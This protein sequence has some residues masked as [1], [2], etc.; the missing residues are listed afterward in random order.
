[1][2]LRFPSRYVLAPWSESFAASL[3]PLII[4]SLVASARRG[5]RLWLT[6]YPATLRSS[7]PTPLRRGAGRPA[8]TAL[9]GLINLRGCDPK[10]PLMKWSR[11]RMIF[12]NSMSALFHEQYRSREEQQ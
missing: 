11:P 12:V 7:C 6:S 5:L 1:M 3:A 4:V 8:P 9:G 10:Y 2:R